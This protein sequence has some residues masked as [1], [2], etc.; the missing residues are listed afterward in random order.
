MGFTLHVQEAKREA[1]QGVEHRK[2]LGAD[3][4][5]SSTVRKKPLFVSRC[6]LLRL[7]LGPTVPLTGL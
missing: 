1:M 5:G 6:V 3:K 4:A 2:T 7:V